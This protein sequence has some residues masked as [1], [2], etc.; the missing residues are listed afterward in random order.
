MI[1]DSSAILAIAFQEPEATRFA[2]AIASAPD[3]FITTINWL[4]TMMV[5]ESGTDVTGADEASLILNQLGVKTLPFDEAHMQEAYEAWQRYGKGRHPA[6][7]NLGDCCAYA[8]SK[9][10]DR[11]LLFKGRDFSKTDVV[12]A[13]Y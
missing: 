12:K 13:V 6:A 3:R 7:L 5:I 8:A 1:V 9:I 10:E 2:S 4:E 11:P